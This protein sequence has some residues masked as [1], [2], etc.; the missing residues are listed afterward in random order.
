MSQGFMQ[1]VPTLAKLK[2]HNR[3]Y[4]RKSHICCNNILE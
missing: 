1:V 3:V 2:Q 4:L